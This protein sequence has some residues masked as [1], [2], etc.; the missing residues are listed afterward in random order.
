MGLSGKCGMNGQ[1]L[2]QKKFY[3]KG[4]KQK[5]NQI[6][7]ILFYSKEPLVQ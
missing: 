2:R 7:N 1:T 6:D 4:L 3:M 5:Y